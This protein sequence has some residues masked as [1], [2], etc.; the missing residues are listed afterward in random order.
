MMSNIRKGITVLLAGCMLLGIAGCGAQ[1]DLSIIE[2]GADNKANGQT[3]LVLY[4]P[5]ATGNEMKEGGIMASMQLAMDEFEVEHPGVQIAYKSYTGRNYQE[6]SYDDVCIERIRNDMGDDLYVMNPDVA[7]EMNQEGRLADLSSLDAV[8][9]LTDAARNQCTVDGKVISV[10]MT[11]LCYGLFV[12]QD[13]LD[14]YDLTLP[15]T[16]DD[17]LHCCEVLKSNGITP[18]GANRWWMENFVLTQGFAPLYMEDGK[19]EKIAAL[20]SGE[21]PISQYMR[22]GF[23]FLAELIEKKYFDVDFAA[24][25]EAGDEKDM[26]MNGQVAFVIH[27]DTAIQ[28][29]SYGSADFNLTMI[30]FPTD[31]YGQVN[32]LNAAQRVCLNKASTQ[33]ELAM[34]FAEKLTSKE[35]VTNALL[36]SGGF[37]SRTDIAF[38]RPEILNIVYENVDAGRAIP[39]S[40]PEIKVEQWGNTCTMVQE[41]LSGKSVDEVMADYDTLQMEQISK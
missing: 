29:E 12:N 28:P 14:Q 18:I 21:T 10:P 7:Y 11:M 39:G 31:E 20:N 37:P 19:A 2:Q 5:I 23:T 9:Y 26:F 24:T 6:K 25:A 36:N 22:P 34:E 40:N 33:Q 3:E 8:Q 4:S 38:E 35:I 27:Y 41:L 32:L 17:F 30:G 15:E 16:T 1:N 13:L